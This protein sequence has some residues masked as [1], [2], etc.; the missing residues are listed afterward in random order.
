MFNLACALE[1][2]KSCPDIIKLLMTLTFLQIF[3][4]NVEFTKNYELMM[5]IYIQPLNLSL[6]LIN[7]HIMNYEYLSTTL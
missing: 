5:I 6:C 7:R 3:H 2:L 1:K 4:S